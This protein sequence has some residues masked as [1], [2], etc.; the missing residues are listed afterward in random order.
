MATARCPWRGLGAGPVVFWMRFHLIVLQVERLLGRGRGR[1]HFEATCACA[2]EVA[3]PISLLYEEDPSTLTRSEAER[4]QWRSG[5][6]FVGEILPEE[7]ECPICDEIY[8]HPCQMR[9]GKR[10]CKECMEK[11]R[12]KSQLCPFCKEVDVSSY[13]DVAHM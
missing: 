4:S 12:A 9:C 7:G 6:E 13:T 2:R 3:I 8:R 11:I 1:L 10:I 5:Y